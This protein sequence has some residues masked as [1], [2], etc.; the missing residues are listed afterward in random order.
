[1]NNTSDGSPTAL[2]VIAAGDNLAIVGNNGTIERSY[3]S[4]TP[5]FRLFDVASGASLTLDNLTL[6]N[7][8]VFDVPIPLPLYG[9]AIYSNGSLTLTGVIV[10]QNVGFNGAGVYIAG[11]TANLSNDTFTYNTCYNAGLRGG[12]AICIAGGTAN[13]TNDTFE[14]N[15]MNSGAFG[16]AVY[17]GGGTVTLTNDLVQHNLGYAAIY[18]SSAVTFSKDTVKDNEGGGILVASPGSAS[19]DQFTV[20]HFENNGGFDIEYLY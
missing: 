4:G 13:L 6:Q 17:V 8:D 5:A 1:V 16:S 2:P 10:T 15:G 19:I 12:G 18:I 3:A 20:H 11:G 7:G 14:Q 9:G